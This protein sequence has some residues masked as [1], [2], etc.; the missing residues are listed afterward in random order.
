MRISSNAKIDA[1]LDRVW[2]LLQDIPRVSTC[3]PGTQIT[4][5]VNDHTWKAKVGVKVGPLTIGYNATITRESLDPV[6][7]AATMRVDAVDAKGRGTVSALVTT[8]AAAVGDAT[9][10]DVQAD[11]NISG[12][13]AQLGQGVVSQVSS[14]LLKIFA[15]NVGKMVNATV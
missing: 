2:D 1:P 8:T 13:V 4:E 10:I 11:A 6:R 7:H 14:G 12:M 3:M 9:Q 15:T 5:T